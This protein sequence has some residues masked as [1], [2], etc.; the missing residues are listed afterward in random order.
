M[1][2]TNC[3]LA[4]RRSFALGIVASLGTVPNA[5]LSE[6]FTPKNGSDDVTAPRRHHCAKVGL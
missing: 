5:S 3:G 4:A 1:K 6:M 2:F